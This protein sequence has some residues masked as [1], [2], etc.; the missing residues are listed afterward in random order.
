MAE[1]LS[2]SS[3]QISDCD[4]PVYIGQKLVGIRDVTRTLI[5]GGGGGG[6]GCLFIYS[7]SARRISFGSELI[8]KE[9][10]RV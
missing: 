8:L 3:F 6:G 9:I 5:W 7:C 2:S 1:A 10:R 4:Q